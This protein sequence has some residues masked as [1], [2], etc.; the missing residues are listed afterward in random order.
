MIVCDEIIY[1]MDI[2][3][4]NLTSI[5]SADIGKKQF[6]VKKSKI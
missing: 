5:I 6:L 1:F 2:V 3:S 4:T